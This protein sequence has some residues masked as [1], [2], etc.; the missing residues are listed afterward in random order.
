MFITVNGSRIDLSRYSSFHALRY[1]YTLDLVRSLNGGRT[2][3]LGGHPW[4]MTSL[5]LSEFSVDL[6]ATISAEEVTAWTEEVPVSSNPYRIELPDGS[7]HEWIN[8]SANLERT[9]INDCFDFNSLP[10][11]DLVLACEIIEHLTRSPHIMLLNINSLLNTGGRVVLTTPNGCQFDNPFRTKPKMPSYRYSQYSRHNYLFTMDMLCDLVQSCGFEIE[12]TTFWSPY[13]R[14]GFASFY[15]SLSRL[16]GLYF[17]NLFSQSI[18]VVARKC[19]DRVTA[20]RLPLCYSY[21]DQW[22]N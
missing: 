21:S 8:I 2:I 18:V 20:S 19:E 7:S 22:E 10:K 9:I 4:S 3:E 12:Y 6:L 15:R 1:Q 14:S 17:K 5:L 16:P 13:R 11:A